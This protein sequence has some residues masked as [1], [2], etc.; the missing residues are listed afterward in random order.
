MTRGLY[1]QQHLLINYER[2]FEDKV[3]WV[4]PHGEAL[5]RSL[6]NRLFDTSRTRAKGVKIHFEEWMESQKVSLVGVEPTTSALPVIQDSL[7]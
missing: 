3:F 7:K 4:I 5:D 2:S 6:G 1:T